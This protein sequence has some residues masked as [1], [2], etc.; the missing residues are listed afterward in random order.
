MTWKQRKDAGFNE[1]IVSEIDDI[2]LAISQILV[3]LKN[4]QYP[5]M[6]IPQQKMVIKSGCHQL[7]LLMRKL[8]PGPE[9]LKKIE[10]IEKKILQWS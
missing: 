8:D 3:R 10:V 6:F 9:D 4:N 5:P 1:E 2:S 7:C